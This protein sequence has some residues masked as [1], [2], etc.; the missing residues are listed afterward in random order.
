MIYIDIDGLNKGKNKK[1]YDIFNF[2][3][4]PDGIYPGGDGDIDLETFI[5]DI[6]YQGGNRGFLAS[7]WI[8]N[9]INIKIIYI[10]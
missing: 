10:I 6:C 1:G 2:A 3:L 5:N 8:V 9:Y 4:T 7:Y